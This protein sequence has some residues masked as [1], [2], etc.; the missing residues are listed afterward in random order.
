MEDSVDRSSL[1]GDA[2]LYTLNQ[3]VYLRRYLEDGHLSIDNNSAERALKNFAVGRRNWLFA[4]SVR[5][6]DASALVYSITETALLNHLKPYAYLT[7]ILDELRKMG[8]FPKEE[9]LKKLANSARTVRLFRNRRY[10]H[11]DLV[12][13]VFCSK[14]YVFPLLL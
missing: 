3:E 1:I 7:Y 9:E 14:R 10:I 11:S 12:V 13:R 8:A 6:A 4:K 2:I 5:G